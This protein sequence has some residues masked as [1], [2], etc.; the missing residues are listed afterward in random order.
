[1]VKQDKCFPGVHQGPQPG[2]YFSWQVAPTLVS[3]QFQRILQEEGE[4]VIKVLSP[5]PA[6]GLSHG[7]AL[8]A[9]ERPKDPMSTVPGGLAVLVPL[10]VGELLAVRAQGVV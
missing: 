10:R 4:P 1:M 9:Q 8:T 2:E 7:S 6:S 3:D 5:P